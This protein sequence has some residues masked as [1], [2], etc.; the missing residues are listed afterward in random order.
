M[1]VKILFW[2]INGLRDFSVIHPLIDFDNVD[3]L[4]LAESN[5]QDDILLLKTGLARVK[6]KIEMEGMALT[7]KV[8]SRINVEHYNTSASGRL[9]FF[10]LDTNEMDE[11]ILAG[12]HFPSKAS[13]NEETQTDLANTYANW[14]RDIESQ[15]KHSKTIVV[16]DFNMNP[17]EKGMIGP[18]AFNATLSYDIAQKGKRRF[19]YED[20]EYFYNPMWNYLGDRNHHTGKPK[21]AGSYFY[22]S[23]TDKSQIYWNVFDKV[24][25]R[26]SVID[27]VD[28]TTI[29][30]LEVI[31]RMEL[32]SERKEVDHLPLGFNLKLSVK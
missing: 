10:L 9:S 5:I 21:L 13:Y 25:V 16:G 29:E 8:Y 28:Y 1:A 19:H 12:I 3:I 11:I 18:H 26:P 32:Q 6:P 17:F 24:I 4:L 23:T 15:R 7:P 30:I 27:I 14:I 2:N 20:F 22:Q 31:P